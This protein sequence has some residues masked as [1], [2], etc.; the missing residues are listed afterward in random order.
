MEHHM[1][2]ALGFL[3]CRPSHCWPPFTSWYNFHLEGWLG[4][5][6][7]FPMSGI[8]STSSLT[9][10]YSRLIAPDELDQLDNLQMRQPS[11][12]S[13]AVATVRS[14]QLNHSSEP[15]QQE[16]QRA[17]TAVGTAPGAPHFDARTLSTIP[18]TWFT[19]AGQQHKVSSTWTAAKQCDQICR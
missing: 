17:G 15:Y 13:A 10:A 8:I 4:C 19:H 18:Q 1:Q 9:D 12:R 14:V 7:V 2:E 6:S 16:T 5:A 11:P 3:A